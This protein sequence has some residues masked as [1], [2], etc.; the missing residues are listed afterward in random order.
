M[1]LK[2]QQLKGLAGMNV[3]N[4]R[5]VLNAS[6]MTQQNVTGFLQVIDLPCLITNKQL[7]ITDVS[8]FARVHIP[9]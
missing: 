1:D 6:S 9:R 4:E 2:L 8:I 3:L 5:T 7:F